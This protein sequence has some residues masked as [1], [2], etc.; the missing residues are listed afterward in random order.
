MEEQK[1][2]NEKAAVTNVSNIT[3]LCDVLS[4]PL[5]RKRIGAQPRRCVALKQQQVKGVGTLEEAKKFVRNP[6]SSQAV[7][8][9]VKRGLVGGTD[10]SSPAW[11]IIRQEQLD[12]PQDCALSLKDIQT[13]HVEPTFPT[14]N[15]N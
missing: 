12:E 15:V 4:S 6:E 14:N 1:V 8:N 11:N 10:Y 3:D 2:T 5:I 7:R 13:K 9:C